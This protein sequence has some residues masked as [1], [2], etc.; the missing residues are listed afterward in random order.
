MSKSYTEEFHTQML[1]LCDS[2]IAMLEEDA[3]KSTNPDEVEMLKR[4]IQ[5]QKGFR[6][7]CQDKLKAIAKMTTNEIKKCEAD[8]KCPKDWTKKSVASEIEAKENF[9]RMCATMNMMVYR[10]EDA[11]RTTMPTN[12]VQVDADIE[13]KDSE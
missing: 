8:R 10:S 13:V 7:G 12:A 4:T 11:R 1:E 9:A 5:F 6:Q 2:R 3:E